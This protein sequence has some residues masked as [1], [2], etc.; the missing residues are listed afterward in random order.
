MLKLFLEN[1]KN[2]ILIYYLKK[3]IDIDIFSRVDT[4]IIKNTGRKSEDCI[5]IH[6]SVL[7][8]NIFLQE[9]VKIKSEVSCSGKIDI[10]RYTSISGP[11]TRLSGK[12]YGIKVGNFCSIASNVIIQ[13]DNHNFNKVTTY[14]INSNLIKDSQENEL[15]SKGKIIIEDDVWIGSNVVILSGVKIGRGSIIGAG[16]VVTKNI[17]PYSIIGGNPSKLI[18]KRFSENE[19]QYLENLK[20]WT[21]DKKKIIENKCIFKM[22]LRELVL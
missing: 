7:R 20:W 13:E 2:K 14:F 18:R 3:N 19:I 5:E 4:K 8:G 15:I 9:G 6:R 11:S 12:K 1:I 22:N 16:S 21:W 10:G 17:E